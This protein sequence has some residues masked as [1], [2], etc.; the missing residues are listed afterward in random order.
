MVSKLNHIPQSGDMVEVGEFIV[1]VVD[2]DERR[3]DKVLIRPRPA[4]DE[5]PAEDSA[6]EGV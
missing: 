2:M 1:E 6:S 4:K 5:S 3:I